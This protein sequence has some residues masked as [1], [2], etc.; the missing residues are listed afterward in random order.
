MTNA[1]IQ[2]RLETKGIRAEDI[3]HKDRL[4]DDQIAAIDTVKIYQWI[5]TGEW[6]QKGFN[7]WLKVMQV[8][9]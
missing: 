7:R 2:A 6:K 5:R 3:K 8:L 1:L 9:D 4:T